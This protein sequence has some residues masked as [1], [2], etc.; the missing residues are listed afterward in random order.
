[1]DGCSTDIYYNPAN[2]T[3]N[4]IVTMPNGGYFALGYGTNM[5]KTDMVAWLASGTESSQIQMY[6]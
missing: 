5:L 3:I 6:S 1:M 2:Q 4:Y